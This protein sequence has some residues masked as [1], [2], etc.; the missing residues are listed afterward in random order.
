MKKLI[1]YS[2]V[3]ALAASALVGCGGNEAATATTAAPK[4]TQAAPAATQAAGNAA[5]AETEAAPAGLTYPIDT[6]VT[7]TIAVLPDAKVTNTYENYGDA[8]FYK[9]L[10]ERTGIK[11]E[12]QH[13]ADVKA[14][15]LMLMSGDMPDMVWGRTEMLPGGAQVC[16]EDGI[17]LP[18]NDYMDEYM[19]DYKALLENNEEYRKMASTADGDVWGGVH[20]GEG[21]AQLQ[22]GG[23]MV[24]QDWLDD[25]GMEAPR[26][27][28]QFYEM[29]K[30]FKE[31]KGA[32]VPFSP[33]LADMQ[34]FL[35]K[36]SFADAFG[37]P[38]SEYYHLDGKVHYGYAEPEMKD[39]LAYMN[40]LYNEGLLDPEFATLDDATEK[41]NILTGRSGALYL[42]TGSTDVYRKAQED[43]NYWLCGLSPLV[44]NEGDVSRAGLG[45]GLSKTGAFVITTSCE[46]PE[47]AAMLMNYGY[48]EEGELFYNFGT[49]G[50]TWNYNEAGEPTFTDL[51][52]KNPDGMSF[53]DAVGTM[54]HGNYGGPFVQRQRYYEQAISVDEHRTAAWE[55]FSVTNWADH[56]ISS[57]VAVPSELLDEYSRINAEVTTFIDEMVVSYITGAKSLDSFDSEYM[58]NLKSMKIDRMI[59]IYQIAYDQYVK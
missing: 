9:E 19:P 54:A 46:N 43:P 39:L 14:L 1:S 8:P 2:L 36:S 58:A 11:L 52:M 21:Y 12:F 56:V 26:T 35:L 37:L 34:D 45:T 15:Q 16:V 18:L 33:T 47:I 5:P 55:R 27:A 17:I 50:E 20:V 41:S 13:A 38:S 48:S 10:Q 22:T 28:D 53:A 31:Q 57:G 4:A 42:L 30:A 23:L 6:D 49:E 51:I 44:Q 40:K 32:E 24:R 59:E 7:L 25:L 29:L 3:T